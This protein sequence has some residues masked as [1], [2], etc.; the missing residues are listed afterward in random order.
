MLRYYEDLSEAEIA[1]TLSMAPGTVKSHAHA[2]SRRL[3][4]LL[5]EPVVPATQTRGGGDAMTLDERLTNAAHG[6][7][8]GLTPPEVDLDVVRRRARANQRRT[9]ALVATGAVVAAVVAATAIGLGREST[10]PLP[11]VGPRP[12]ESVEPGFQGAGACELP[13][14][15]EQP[16]ATATTSADLGA[17]IDSLPAGAPPVLPYW[18]DGVLHVDGAEIEA[19][20]ADVEH[21]DGGR[22]GHGGRLRRQRTQ[23]A[24]VGVV[25]APRR[26]AR[27]DA[28]AARQ[29]A[30]AEQR[31]QDRLLVDASRRAASTRYFTWDT[32]TRSAL[33]TRTVRGNEE[34]SDGMCRVGVLGVDEDGIAYLIDQANDPPITAWDVRADTL[35]PTDLTYDPALAPSDQYA[36]S[37]NRNLGF[38]AAYVSP[39]GTREV[40][41]GSVAGDPTA[42]CCATRIRVRPA[43][44]AATVERHDVVPLQLPDGIPAMAC[45]TP[46]PT[47]APGACGGRPT[48]R[49]CWTRRSAT[50]AI[51][52]AAR[53]TAGPASWSSTSVPTRS[54]E[55]LYMPDWEREWG[56][57][58]LPLTE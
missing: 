14:Y 25:A 49:C 44:S 26:C 29:L 31:R 15:V 36:F 52:C 39:D 24:S 35:E 57:A 48:R 56:F 4:E 3:A 38:E 32:E 46:T 33:A 51:S 20:Y 40:F 17:W 28:R 55:I 13:P 27:A 58:R 6:L 9:V 30:G 42:D 45:G 19:P 10:A 50:T 8:D 7:A 43:G 23:Q 54:K 41:T 11:P 21:R 22:H 18:H 2:A 34:S 37:W 12:S 5:R 16:E 47:A 1:R 53:P